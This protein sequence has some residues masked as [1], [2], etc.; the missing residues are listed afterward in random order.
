MPGAA[1]L[2][3]RHVGRPRSVTSIDIK[4]LVEQARQSNG[5]I[6]VDCAVGDTVLEETSLLR[7]YG[8]TTGISQQQLRGAIRLGSQRTFEQDPK[9]A[10]R[11]LVDVAIKALSPA[12][13]DPTTAVQA[14]DQIEDLL[15]RLAK[16][17]LETCEAFDGEGRLRVVYQ[18]PSWGDYLAL[19]FDEIRQFGLS[20][21]QVMRRLRAALA[22]LADCVGSERA[23]LVIAYLKHLDSDIDRSA[24]DPLDRLAARVEDR[25]GLGLS[26]RI[27]DGGGAPS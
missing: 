2:T 19:A 3:I 10:L 26:H 17:D 15:R 23:K 16:C 7:L 1:T 4:G 24:F 11:L 13:N 14:I 20:S 25:Q 27:A 9:Y 6:V 18:M 21:I 5:F 8:D 12:V 22:E